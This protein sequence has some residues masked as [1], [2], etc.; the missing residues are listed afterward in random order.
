MDCGLP[1]EP[2]R[3]HRESRRYGYVRIEWSW[4]DFGRHERE[5]A[6]S[7][8]GSQLYAPYGIKSAT[9]KSAAKK[10]SKEPAAAACSYAKTRPESSPR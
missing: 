8:L 3:L 10:G 9:G 6:D 7:S 2:V 4:N 5:R 1:N